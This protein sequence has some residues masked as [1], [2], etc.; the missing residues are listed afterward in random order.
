M[1]TEFG[2]L[3]SEQI[4]KFYAEDTGVPS[5]CLRPG[6]L[7]GPGRDLGLTSTPTTAMKSV[8]LGVPYEIPFRSKQDYLFAP[9]VGAA[10]GIALTQPFSGFGTF[11]LPGHTLEMPEVVSAIQLAAEDVGLADQCH[12]SFGNDEV[13]FI[14]DIEFEPAR[15]AFPQFPLTEFRSGV[16]QS[17]ET[18]RSYIKKGWLK[19]T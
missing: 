16:A 19:P 13:P 18:F 9:D 14:C 4:L 17:L 8:A 15:G 7:Y 1:F 11:T 5:V 12:I 2:N 10:F 6:V 3:P